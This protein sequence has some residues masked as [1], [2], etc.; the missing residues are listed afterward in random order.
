MP[1]LKAYVAVIY[2]LMQGNSG[3]H[4]DFVASKMS[5]APLKQQTIPWLE[6]LAALL[7]SRLM[8]VVTNK[9]L[10]DELHISQQCC[11]TNSTVALYCILDSWT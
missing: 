1:P 11:Y 8:S 6:L 9:A 4:V 5:V 3:P 10:Q 2:L 7:L